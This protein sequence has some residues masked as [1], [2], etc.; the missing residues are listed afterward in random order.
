MFAFMDTLRKAQGAVLE[1]FGFGPTECAYHLL[2]SGPR[3]RL[4]DYGGLDAGPLLLIVAAPTKR[5][6]L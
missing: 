2:A 5:S 4:R 1:E 3:W 6:Y